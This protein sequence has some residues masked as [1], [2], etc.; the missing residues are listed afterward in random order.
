VS[1][2]LFAAALAAMSLAAS[3]VLAAAPAAYNDAAIERRVS[4]LAAEL[5]CLVCQNQSLADSNAP[6]AVDLKN[7]IR[8]KLQRGESESQVVSFMVERY[9]DFVLY[10]PPVNGTTIAL[11]IGPLLFVAAGLFLLFQRLKRA[12][13]SHEQTLS[14]VDHARAASLLGTGEEKRG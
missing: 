7:E 3:L 10:R 9:G 8:E 4:A 12:G 1:R 11:W 5:R 2:G 14:A 6:L 13:E